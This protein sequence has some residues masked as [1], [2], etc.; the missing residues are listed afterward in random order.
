MQWSPN[1]YG[2]DED[3]D[4]KERGFVVL[5]DTE[6][7]E[8]EGGDTEIVEEED[9][10]MERPKLTRQMTKDWEVRMSSHSD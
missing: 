3:I 1:I 2:N 8:E 6:E 5:D 10:V 9:T 7:E 4:P